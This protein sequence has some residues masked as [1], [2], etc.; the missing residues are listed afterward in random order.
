MHF[1]VFISAMT[2][3]FGKIWFSGSESAQTGF[4]LLD[5]GGKASSTRITIQH[6]ALESGIQNLESSWPGILPFIVRV[7]SYVLVT[8]FPGLFLKSRVFF[9]A[10][11][12]PFFSR[13]PIAVGGRF[14]QNLRIK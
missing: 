5:S 7:D 3:V 6:A 8:C 1:P 13:T 12:L 9:P 10:E 2:T 4:W 14:T 11:I